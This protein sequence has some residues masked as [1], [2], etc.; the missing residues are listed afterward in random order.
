MTR[1]KFLT[2]LDLSWAGLNSRQLMIFS[3]SLVTEE[4]YSNATKG[5][6]TARNYQS[7]RCLNLSYNTL[8]QD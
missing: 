3:R 4:K 1:N 2:H 8:T 6:Y 5:G 7:L